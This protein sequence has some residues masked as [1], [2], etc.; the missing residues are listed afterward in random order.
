MKIPRRY[1]VFFVTFFLLVSTGCKEGEAPLSPSGLQALTSATDTILLLWEDNSENEDGFILER[2][3]ASTDYQ[4]IATTY[5]DQVTFTDTGLVPGAEYVYRVAAFNSGG[6]SEYCPELTVATQSLDI[7]PPDTGIVSSEPDPDDY[8]D[9][10]FEFLCDDPP[11]TFE[12]QIDEGYWEPC[13]SPVTYQ[14]L[15][16][17]QGEYT[18]RVRAV[19]PSGNVDPTPSESTFEYTVTRGHWVDVSNENAP[20]PRA[21]HTAVKDFGPWGDLRIIIWGGYSC[22]PPHATYCMEEYA[23]AVST[24]GMYFSET[25]YWEPITDQNAPSPRAQHTAVMAN[26]GMIVWGG[27]R[28]FGLP[29]SE[30]EYLGDGGIYIP[31]HLSESGLETWE[32]ISDVNAPSAR[33]EHTAVWTGE[34]MIIWGGKSQLGVLDTGA[35]YNP[36]TDTWSPVSASGAPSP[37]FWH[38]AVWTGE[39]M[40]IW[41]GWNGSESFDNG[42]RLG[43]GARYNPETDT[44]IPMSTE[45]APGPR[46]GHTAVLFRHVFE[47]ERDMMFIWGGDVGGEEESVRG[48]GAVYYP[49]TDT[50]QVIPT[51]GAPAG[52]R[53]HHAAWTPREKMVVWGGEFSSCDAS[54]PYYDPFCWTCSGAIYDPQTGC[55][56]DTPELPIPE[57]CAAGSTSIGTGGIPYVMMI[58]GGIYGDEYTVEIEFTN[59]GYGFIPW[60]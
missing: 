2:K 49:D 44:W 56:S 42:E 7:V 46:F 51:K 47:Y 48:T 58:W 55:W 34:E 20:S 53:F 18:F 1:I 28:G 57:I 60:Y 11:C 35:R 13:T 8:P 29:S 30:K 45:G 3:L 37:R 12:C 52:R 32:A 15:V 14:G 43:D 22:V 59:I 36:E 40:I 17:C 23:E 38:T 31:V 16:Q 5:P 41:G 21:Y 39:E 6:Q 25:D 4:N 10:T 27:S 26:S 54:N 19:D 24:G 33:D 9:A 50:W